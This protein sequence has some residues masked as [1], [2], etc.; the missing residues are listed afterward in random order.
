[1]FA[2][3]SD[4]APTANPYTRVYDYDG[5]GFLLYEGWARAGIVDT[6]PFWAI[7]RYEYDGSG[8]LLRATWA[9]GNSAQDNAWNNRASLT[10]A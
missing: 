4:G 3:V 8:R 2:D 6:A 7:R 10:Y 5:S 1:M 9:D